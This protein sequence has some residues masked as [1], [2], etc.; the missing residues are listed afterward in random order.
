MTEVEFSTISGGKRLK[1]GF[2]LK[3]VKKWYPFFM[4]NFVGQSSH[5]L[6]M[7]MTQGNKLHKMHSLSVINYQCRF[8]YQNRTH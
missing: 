8:V 6:K 7:Q 2:N 5:R 3:K 4:P 1:L